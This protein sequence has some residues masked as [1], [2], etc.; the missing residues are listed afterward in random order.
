MTSTASLWE[1]PDTLL[2]EITQY[3]VAST[4]R[5]SFLCHKIAILCRASRSRILDD[6]KSA[7][8]WN[9]VLRGDYGIANGSD[10]HGTS[11]RR[12]C[13]R[14]RRNPLD[15]VQDAHKLMRD[16]TEIAYYYLWEM[17]SSN[18]SSKASK[19]SLT[20]AN[21]VRILNTYG[22]Q[23]MYNKTMSSGGTFLVEVC[24]CRNAKSAATILQCIQEL[25]ERRGALINKAT[26]ESSNSTLTPLC[27]AAV[28]G[29][30]KVVEYILSK[31]ALRD[32]PC[33]GRFR[34]HTN[35]KRSIRCNSVTA[36]KFAEAMLQAELEE[37]AKG[38]DLRDLKSCIKL[39]QE[40]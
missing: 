9:A 26:N 34:L 13:K 36:L 12:S 6:S 10:N 30:P 15:Q 11:R 19:N 5:A 27:V 35:P 2:Y 3:C 8:L 25:V 24:R 14:L 17:S 4:Q 31:G 28:R 1:L 16:N 29:M 39:L 37:G 21:L 18:T 38:T 7:G 20:R 22:P 40:K 33:S 32:N 23:L